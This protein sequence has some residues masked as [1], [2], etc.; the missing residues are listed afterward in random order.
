MSTPNSP[1]NIQALLEVFGPNAGLVE[2]LLREYLMNPG[3]V[4]KS[5]QHYFSSMVPPAKP[6]GHRQENLPPTA[7]PPRPAVPDADRAGTALKGV[8]A[9][10]VENMEAS[11]ALPTATSVRTMPVKVMEENRRLLNQHLSVRQG[12]KISFTH[13]ISWAIVRALH[14]F[15]NMNAAFARI[16]GIPHRTDRPIINIGL[17]IDLT[18]RDGARSLVVPNVKDAGSMDF[19]EFVAAYDTIV[20]RARG[21]SLEPADFQG[22][23][24]TLTNP[25]T[26]GT[27]SSIPRLMPGQGAIIATG[28]INFPAETMGMSPE[29]LSALGMSKVMTMT[30]TYD[31]R[32][33]QGAESGQFLARIEH[34][35]LG[36]DHFY[37]SLFADLRIPY[38]PVRWSR[39]HATVAGGIREPAGK[40]AKIMQLINAYRV[41][42]HLIAHLDPL[43]NEPHNHPELDPANYDLTVWDLDREFLTGGLGGKQSASLREILDILR[44][45]YCGTTGVEYMNIQHPEQKRWLQDK[46]EPSRNRAT[47]PGPQR[48]NALTALT[49]AE[50]LEKFLHTKFIGHKRF[51]LEGA[52]TLMPILETLLNDGAREGVEEI[53]IGMAHRGRLN[54]LANTIGKSVA[55]IFSEFE[56]Y[57]DPSTIQGSGDVKYHLGARGRRTTTDGKN[58]A[59]SV[60]PNPSH[61]EAVNPVVEGI[62]RA[63]QDRRGEGAYRN[64]VPV[65]IHGDAAFAG[66]GVIA[67][68]FNL[69]QLDGYRTSGTIHIIINNQIGFTT[70][71]DDARSTPYCTDVAKMVQAP[72]FHVNGDDVDA[73]LRVARLALEYRQTFRKDVVIDM[74]CYRRHGHNEGDEPSYTQPLLYR[75]IRQH[76]SVRRI[77]ADTLMREKAL[78]AEQDETIATESHTR[79]ERAFDAAQKRELHFT[80]EVPLAVSP[81]E[82]AAVQ[83]AHGTAIERLL[84]EDITRAL[85]SVPSGFSVHPKLVRM[86]DERRSL[87]E[88]EA[89]IDWALAEAIAFGSLLCEGTPVRLSGQDSRRGTF[90]QRHLVL[91]DAQTGQEYIPLNSIREG[92]AM[93]S[94]Y[95]SLLS[96]AAVL[97][98]EFGYSTAD[99]LALVLWEAQF[100]D[101]A[102]GAQVIIDQFI[103]GSEAKWQEP[104]DLVLLLPHG[105][106]GQGPDHS[107]ARL[108][109]FLQLCAEDNMQ[110]CNCTTPAQYFH[111]LRRQ[112]R[113]GRRKPLIIMTPKSLLRY[114]KAVSTAGDITEGR[115]LEVIDEASRPEPSSIQR[116]VLCAGKMYYDLLAGRDAGRAHSVAIVRVEQ[117]YPFPGEQ[118]R[119]ILSAYS[120]A[121]T[122]V[123]TQEEPKNMGAWSFLEPRLRAI[124]SSEQT[125]R[126]AGR[127]ASASTATGS[128]KVH[129]EEQA[130]IVTSALVE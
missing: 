29:N 27:N 90:S 47:P 104:C 41:R 30:S 75:K 6:N 84:L 111:L 89:K 54:V 11:L 116:V 129:Q 18:R 72:I 106:E 3:N 73:A 69:S 85:G 79:Y 109:R 34:L 100:G 105:Y 93:L 52:E 74:F 55:K 1:E 122:I 65:L 57:V 43:V 9:K 78:T 8:A 66:Q 126:Y 20:S 95:D 123:W 48:I 21:N 42:G 130:A 10:I 77:Y 83:P 86:L 39:D 71:P 15:P 117:L 40:Q 121:S 46:M 125:L 102:N 108:E 63:K 127:K 4:S 19:A 32:V 28:A 99:P 13:I 37:D 24:I 119:G 64:V 97:G 101:F 118:L 67:E 50:G 14:D 38:E 81:E 91:F 31:H 98:F 5:W 92:Q 60:A 80:P 110:V 128:L 88:Q 2:E 112:M 36:E 62:V 61:L 59:V 107:S 33:I 120:R 115:F 70:S 45:T 23:S 22:T 96:E 82:V 76:P 87:L 16:E 53:V 44:E 17:A 25:G 26:V 49:A 7:P 51:S 68:T 35:L 114:P 103:A 94:V 113:D 124:L 12:G 58:I 56:G